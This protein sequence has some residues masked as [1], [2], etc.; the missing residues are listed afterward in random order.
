MIICCKNTSCCDA[1]TAD[2]HY[3]IVI[4]VVGHAVVSNR[5]GDSR[6]GRFFDGEYNLCDISKIHTKCSFVGITCPHSPRACFRPT[7]SNKLTNVSSDFNPC[8]VS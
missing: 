5:L 4:D 1:G 8:E 7:A 3:S 6:S 2:L